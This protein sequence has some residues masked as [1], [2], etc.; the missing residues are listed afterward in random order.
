MIED[1]DTIPHH[2]PVGPHWWDVFNE[3]RPSAVATTRR[4]R[5][6]LIVGALVLIGLA[7][8]LAYPVSTP[9]NGN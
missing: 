7:I 1:D 8:I 4:P 5:W 3:P 2:E 9:L 6:P